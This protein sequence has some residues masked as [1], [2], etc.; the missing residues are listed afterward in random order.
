MLC[1]VRCQPLKA[2]QLGVAATPSVCHDREGVRLEEHADGDKEQVSGFLF[3]VWNL[4]SITFYNYKYVGAHSFI[5]YRYRIL[6]FQRILAVQSVKRGR[7]VLHTKLTRLIMLLIIAVIMLSQ[8][9]QVVVEG[10]DVLG[11]KD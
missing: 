5:L 4:F 8:S 6:G 7:T 10:T 9:F 11:I 1:R 3:F 2:A